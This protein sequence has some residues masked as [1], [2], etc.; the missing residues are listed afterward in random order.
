MD[1]RLDSDLAAGVARGDPLALDALYERHQRPT[2]NYL[3]RLTGDRELAQDLTQETFTRVWRKAGTFDVAGNRF[4]G[5]LFTI[6]H[7]LTRSELARRRYRVRHL[8]PPALEGLA[9][10]A[11]CPYALLARGEERRRLAAAVARLHPPLREVVHLR[12]YRQL[13]FG[14]ITALTGVSE[15]TLKVR[16]HRAVLRLRER[17]TPEPQARPQAASESRAAVTCTA[18]PQAA[19]SAKAAADQ[20]SGAAT[21]SRCS[22]ATAIAPAAPAQESAA[23]QS[24]ARRRAARD[25]VQVCAIAARRWGGG[26]STSRS[27]SSRASSSAAAHS[28]R[29]GAHSRR[30]GRRSRGGSL[31]AAKTSRTSSS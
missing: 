7:N 21:G 31:P 4:R 11:P 6:A 26:V 16:F 20:G 9:S 28:A 24:M 5:W 29:Q 15:M 30:C 27:R 2:F 19:A 25:S 1:P 8:G 22:A 10:S 23:A 13:T 17:L 3:W 12:V 14:E 18:K